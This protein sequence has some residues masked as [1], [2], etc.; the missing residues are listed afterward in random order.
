MD[1][2]YL[3]TL[4]ALPINPPAKEKLIAKIVD[5]KHGKVLAVWVYEKSGECSHRV[6]IDEKD[7]HTLDA[8]GK[9]GK[10][11]LAFIL[12]GYSYYYSYICTSDFEVSK[13]DAEII[14]QYFVDIEQFDNVKGYNN[15]TAEYIQAHMNNIIGEKRQAQYARAK[16]FEKKVFALIEPLP[17]DID[18]WANRTLFYKN[19]YMFMKRKKGSEPYKKAFC[20]VCEKSV[21]ISSDNK[22]DEIGH[23]PTCQAEI[24]YKNDGMGRAGLTESTD[25]YIV[26]SADKDIFIR[27]F[28][29]TKSYETACGNAFFKYQEKARYYITSSK[30]HMWQQ[31][32]SK[33]WVSG[34]Y[35]CKKFYSIYNKS[36]AIYNQSL[37]DLFENSCLSGITLDSVMKAKPNLDIINYIKV[38]KKMPM[39]EYIVK[40]RLG[41]I[42]DEILRN[43]DYPNV[44]LNTA[45]TSVHEALKI[46]KQDL[47]LIRKYNCNFEQVKLLTAIRSYDY[48]LDIADW[49]FLLTNTRTSKESYY[50]AD[51]RVTILE[52]CSPKQIVNYL[53]KQMAVNREMYKNFDVL[54]SDWYDYIE[55]VKKLEYDITDQSILRPKNLNERHSVT[56]A[57]VSEKANPE[58]TEKIAKRAVKLAEKYSFQYG[59]YCIVIPQSVYDITHEG[60]M[61]SH[62]VGGYASSHADGSTT[63]LFLRKVDAPGISFYTLEV[64]GNYVVQCRGFKN[65]DT[66]E[67]KEVDEFIE[68]WQKQLK[69]SKKKAVSAA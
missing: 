4:P 9:W 66:P 68:Q 13:A 37:D 8:E 60:A 64:K 29:A 1:K 39:I 52:F 47:Q 61:Q 41:K 46:T 67:R 69:K 50:S 36:S 55:Q 62:C 21:E 65:Q 33:N 40:A 22:R 2:K 28:A 12:Y 49:E 5:T 42:T 45:A 20:S 3:A 35:K 53:N 51:R 26:Q 11:S 10:K 54:L 23:C 27:F 15:N 6:F 30:I 32:I 25:F 59:D 19:N 18:K 31:N 16:E 56:S 24:I 44:N 57:L 14:K 17:S 58:L 48:Y 43:P 63:I 38:Y 7:W 34:F